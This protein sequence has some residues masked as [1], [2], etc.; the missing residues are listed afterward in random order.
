MY[1]IRKVFKFEGSHALTSSYS[2]ECQKIHG[3]S[4]VVEVFLKSEKLDKH[5]MVIDFKII[6]ES[7]GHLVDMF[8][9]KLVVAKD[10]PK[11]WMRKAAEL[12]SPYNPTAEN[13]AK[14]LYE[15]MNKEL[16]IVH[17]SKVRVHE[18]TTGW[19]EYYED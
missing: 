7:V 4:Y 2:K 19:A 10:N 1:Q 5:G 6:K 15:E 11:E 14:F 13:M 3:H 16:Q 8:D 12:T 17:I 18:T 9:H